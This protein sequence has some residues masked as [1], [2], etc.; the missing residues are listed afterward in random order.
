MKSGKLFSTIGELGLLVLLFLIVSASFISVVGLSPLTFEEVAGEKNMVGEV[1][2]EYNDRVIEENR[3]NILPAFAREGLFFGNQSIGENYYSTSVQYEKILTGENKA[4]I[5]KL[6]N[7]AEPSSFEVRISVP[8]DNLK[9]LSIRMLAN[10]ESIRLTDGLF[11]GKIF[12]YRFKVEKGEQIDLI[13]I[14]DSNIQVNYPVI[15]T[16]E[17]EK[18]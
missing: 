12:P 11:Q 17:L 1:A 3:I 10:G 7:Q 14:L 13:L 16:F 4:E 15:V 2:G 9:N 8:K 5:L 18:I 6:V